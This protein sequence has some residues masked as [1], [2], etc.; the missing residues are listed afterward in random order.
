MNWAHCMNL[1]DRLG[2]EVSLSMQKCMIWWETAWTWWGEQSVWCT[3]PTHVRA[4]P[5][6][7]IPGGKKGEQTR[8]ADSDPTSFS[9]EINDRL[10]YTDNV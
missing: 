4:N 10:I 6:L 2:S 8:L 9:R 7:R 5:G 3:E 1:R